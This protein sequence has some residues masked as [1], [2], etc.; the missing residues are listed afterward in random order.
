MEQS[1]MPLLEALIEFGKK[2][3][4]YFRIPAHRFDRGVGELLNSVPPAA[5]DLSE[6]EGLDDLH[7][8]SGVILEAQKLAA[9][10]WGSAEAWFLVNGTTCGN[11]AMVL[12]AAVEGEKIIIPR[13]AHKSVLMGMI[14]SGAEPVYIN[15]EYCEDWNMWG[16]VTPEAVEEAFERAPDAKAV[17]LVCPTYYGV[18]SDLKGI[19]GVCHAHGAALLVD[20]AHGSHLYFDPAFPPG[21]LMQGA[22]LVAQSIH[23][24]GGS[25]TQSSLLH[26]NSE[27]ISSHTIQASLHMVQSTSPSYLLMAS[28]DSARHE[29]AVHGREHMKRQAELSMLARKLLAEIPG[30]RVLSMDEED[31][32]R[33]WR[34]DPS[35]LVFSARELGISGYRLHELLYE[36]DGVSCELS[37][38][39]NVVA[40]ITWAN[41]E[42][43]ILR[44]SRALWKISETYAVLSSRKDEGKGRVSGDS[45]LPLPEVA[46]NPR[47]AY[48]SPKRSIP[49]ALAEGK[50]AG[51]MVVPYP[52]G[53]PIL[54]PGERISAE[55]LAILF[56][57]KA[58]G[59]AFHGPLDEKLET[60]QILEES[61]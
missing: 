39:E 18:L 19:A 12:S 60:L 15:P 53:I 41:T 42:E 11:E 57:K 59:C 21:A 46:V 13:N 17:F 6:A 43:E 14:L 47:R 31:S 44:L 48:F 25:F 4:A 23:K 28:L 10:V 37:D 45:S 38:E 26:R 24:T 32:R 29:L 16:A 8:A 55:I 51:E 49:L 34:L 61:V 5:L 35:R 2:K 33:I 54:Q 50:I 22:D 3:P 7:D 58:D 52:P 20:E 40:V 27:R 36:R 56:R 1:K 30:I 9:Q